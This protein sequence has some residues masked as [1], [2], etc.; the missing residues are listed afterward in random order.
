[1]SDKTPKKTGG[2][3]ETVKNALRSKD[4]YFPSQM[5][6]VEMRLIDFMS[7]KH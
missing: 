1:M 5:A 6:E 7:A 2:R 4:G 3:S